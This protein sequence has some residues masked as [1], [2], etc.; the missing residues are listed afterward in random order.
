MFYI[1]QSTGE[2][3]FIENIRCLDLKFD[4]IELDRLN[5]VY[6][7]YDSSGKC[8]ASVFRKYLDDRTKSKLD[9]LAEF[10]I[11]RRTT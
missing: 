2:T 10:K 8:I 11:A 5:D 6:T 3:F 7:L 4:I 9:S 1:D